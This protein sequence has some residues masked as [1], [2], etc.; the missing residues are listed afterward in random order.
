M[1]NCEAKL[2][3][4]N[5][6]AGGVHRTTDDYQPNQPYFAK[7]NIVAIVFDCLHSY[8]YMLRI[9]ISY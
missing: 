2:Y 5:C 4:F 3:R 1:T 9:R 6:S 8:S 7:D